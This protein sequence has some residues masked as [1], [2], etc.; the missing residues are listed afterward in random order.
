MEKQLGDLEIYSVGMVITC[1][2]I[3]NKS[4]EGVGLNFSEWKKDMVNI[5]EGWCE[6]YVNFRD[7]SHSKTNSCKKIKLFIKK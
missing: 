7:Y 4:Y 1:H 2:S 6:Y 5:K 3:V